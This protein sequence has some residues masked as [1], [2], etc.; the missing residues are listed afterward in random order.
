MKG[1][2]IDIIAGANFS[3]YLEVETNYGKTV[4]IKHS[5]GKAVGRGDEY[6]YDSEQAIAQGV[7]GGIVIS[8]CKEQIEQ[9]R[10]L[11]ITQP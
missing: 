7:K 3:V 4:I 10:K 9:M 2:V 5:K 6:T 8:R 1:T 11:K